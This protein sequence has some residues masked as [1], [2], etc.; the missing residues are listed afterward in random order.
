[1]YRDGYRDVS[2]IA[3]T[4]N[5]TLFFIHVENRELITWFEIITTTS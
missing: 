4:I 2:I 5:A 1:M 3:M